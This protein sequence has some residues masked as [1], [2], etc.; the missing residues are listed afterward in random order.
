MLVR[1]LQNVCGRFVS[2]EWVLPEE[3]LDSKEL[4]SAEHAMVSLS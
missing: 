4:E 1:R 2:E 3:E